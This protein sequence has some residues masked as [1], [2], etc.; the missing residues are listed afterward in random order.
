[1]AVDIYNFTTGDGFNS[2]EQKLHNLVN[3]Y[4]AEFGLD[5]IPASRALSIVANRHV[6]DLAENV[7]TLTAQYA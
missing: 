6:V 7:G 4:R 2:E 3:D 1:M 5:A